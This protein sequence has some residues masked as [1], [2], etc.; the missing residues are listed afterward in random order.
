MGGL[1][2]DDNM[3]TLFSKEGIKGLKRKYVPPAHDDT[4]YVL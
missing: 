2:D 4:L 3:D 1:F